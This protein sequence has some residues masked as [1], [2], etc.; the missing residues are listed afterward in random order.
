ML[1]KI[2]L[3]FQSP[4]IRIPDRDETL[5]VKYKSMF[6][7]KNKVYFIQVGLLRKSSLPVEPKLRNFRKLFGDG[8]H[9]SV[10]FVIIY[11]CLV[12]LFPAD[13]VRCRHIRMLCRQV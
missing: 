9:N 4:F 2:K 12:I 7:N 1:Y 5:I 13:V 3:P 10:I 11:I 6:Q 8:Q